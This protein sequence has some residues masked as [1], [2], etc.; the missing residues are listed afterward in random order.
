MRG[1]AQTEFGRNESAIAFTLKRTAPEP[2]D[3]LCSVEKRPT[4]EGKLLFHHLSND[5]SLTLPNL[6]LT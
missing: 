3:V 1:V 5:F 4:S 6:V 2:V